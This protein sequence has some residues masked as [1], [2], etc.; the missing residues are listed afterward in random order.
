M[1]RGADFPRK[2]TSKISCG[3]DVWPAFL[4][5]FEKQRDSETASIMSDAAEEVHAADVPSEVPKALAEMN[6]RCFASERLCTQ[7]QEDAPEGAEATEESQIAKGTATTDDPDDH[8]DDG[9]DDDDNKEQNEENDEND[10]N[11]ENEENDENDENMEVGAQNGQ[12]NHNGEAEEQEDGVGGRRRKK[13]SFDSQ[14]QRAPPLLFRLLRLQVLRLVRLVRGDRTQGAQHPRGAGHAAQRDAQ[15]DGKHA[16]GDLQR[17]A[18]QDAAHAVPRSGQEARVQ[19]EPGKVLRRD[20]PGRK[21]RGRAR[22]AEGEGGQAGRGGP[23]DGHGHCRHRAWLAV[24]WAQSDQGDARGSIG[25]M[26]RESH[27]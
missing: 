19:G 26:A 7:E 13:V 6:G 3:R 14:H 24:L 23:P 10:E 16:R 2:P 27:P 5:G 1:D 8:D 25:R 15:R 20:F 11:D 21:G 18:S 12:E 22:G 9:N 17:S 4:S